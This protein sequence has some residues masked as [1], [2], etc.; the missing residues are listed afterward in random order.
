MLLVR[1]IQN[2]IEELQGGTIGCPRIIWFSG[3]RGED[4]NVIFYR[5]MPNFHN[6]YKSAEKKSQK[7]T[8]NKC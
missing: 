8:E 2:N 5:N 1:D 7:K 4:L 3:F 6:Q